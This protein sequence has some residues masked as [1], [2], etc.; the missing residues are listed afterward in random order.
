MKAQ[1]CKLLILWLAAALLI[2]SACSLYQYDE[3]YIENQ[4]SKTENENTMSEE[5]STD[6]NDYFYD[7]TCYD[8]DGNEVTKEFFKENEL[9]LVNV[10]AT[11]CGPCKQELPALQAVAD[12]YAEQGFAVLGILHDGADYSTFE[13]SEKA[14]QN[15]KKLMENAEAAY[16]VIVPDINLYRGIL[17]AVT[18]FPTSF[19]V[20]SEGRIL[21]KSFVIGSL[22]EAGWQE[23]T[24]DMLG[25]IKEAEDE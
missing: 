19:Y 23:V 6:I 14:V 22:D 16:T 5:E 20:D 9:T 1:K 24:E 21:D 4:S 12:K 15:G 3:N 11:W 13:R 2:C 8:L 17:S 25:R 10:W 18:A 7:F